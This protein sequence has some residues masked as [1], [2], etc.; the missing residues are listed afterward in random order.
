M[1]EGKICPS[2]LV[3]N[4]KLVRDV[5]ILKKFK[6]YQISTSKIRLEI[7]IHGNN[8]NKYEFLLLQKIS[9][10]SHHLK[11]WAVQWTLYENKYNKPKWKSLKQKGSSIPHHFSLSSLSF[12]EL[13]RIFLAKDQHRHLTHQDYKLAC[14]LILHEASP[15]SYSYSAKND[16]NPEG[17]K[18]EK[19]LCVDS[20]NQTLCRMTIF[21]MNKESSKGEK[22]QQTRLAFAHEITL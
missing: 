2:T 15:P 10:I 19:E 22:S 4:Q 7:P 16:R 14:D 13:S 20:I 5:Y 17:N 11:H 8:T 21:V 9:P 3:T 6:T 12:P 18:K 1:F